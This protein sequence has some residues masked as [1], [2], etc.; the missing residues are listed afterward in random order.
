[1]ADR[2]NGK[3]EHPLTLGPK[4]WEEECG[5]VCVSVC[6]RVHVWDQDGGCRVEGKRGMPGKK[7]SRRSLQSHTFAYTLGIKASS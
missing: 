5:C 3:V 7:H 1:M 6:V 2:D 4:Y